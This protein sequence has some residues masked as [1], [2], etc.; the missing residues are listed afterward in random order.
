M[1]GS[2]KYCYR[3]ELLHLK[4]YFFTSCKYILLVATV[5]KG[6]TKTIFN[7][8]KEAFIMGEAET[9][10]RGESGFVRS[11]GEGQTINL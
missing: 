5:I 7:Q 6:I 4:Q 9:M 10:T 1:T 3:T 11:H 2:K 8:R